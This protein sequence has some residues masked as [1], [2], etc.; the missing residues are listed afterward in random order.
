V[1]RHAHGR[2]NLRIGGFQRRD[3]A[4]PAAD[5]ERILSHFPRLRERLQ[6]PPASCPAAEQQMLVIGR[7]LMTGTAV[8][9]DEPSLG[10]APMIVDQVYDI[11]LSLRRSDGL[12]L[13]INEQ[14]SKPY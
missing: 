8:M 3:R 4:A 10:L 13:L 11:L 1:V 5:F 7:A 6:Q 2:E 12:T 14:S 9:V